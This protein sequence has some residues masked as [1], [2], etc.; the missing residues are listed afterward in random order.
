[1]RGI[2]AKIALNGVLQFAFG[3]AAIDIFN[4]RSYSRHGLARMAIS[5]PVNSEVIPGD[6]L[7]PL[8]PGSRPLVQNRR[9]RYAAV[10]GETQV[11][12]CTSFSSPVPSN[13]SNGSVSR[14]IIRPK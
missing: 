11:G 5:G 9:T 4:R 12:T 2:L 7:T 3:I 10:N 13:V 6:P 14:G 8:L 1:M